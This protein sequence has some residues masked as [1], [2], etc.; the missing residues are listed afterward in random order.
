MAETLTLEGLKADYPALVEEISTN[1]VAAFKASEEQKAKEANLAKL[2]EELDGYKVKE[3][4]AEQREAVATLIEEAKLPEAAV[5]DLFVE[6]LI[7]AEPDARAALIE[8]RRELVKLNASTKP[9][10]KEQHTSE[11]GGA[12]MTTEELG[13]RWTA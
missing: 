13:R 7:A 12:Q 10:S 3:R 4:L 11:G 5:T 8:D 2:Q 6:Q 9:Q 1:A